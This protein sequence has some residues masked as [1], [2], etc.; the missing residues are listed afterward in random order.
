MN[1]TDIEKVLTKVD[2][3]E[4]LPTF[5]QIVR[6]C[7]LNKWKISIS[8]FVFGVTAAIVSSMLPN[9]Y[10][11]EALLVDSS[12]SDSD[13]LD[14]LSNSLGGLASIAGIELNSGD[15]NKAA[16]AQKV[17]VSRHFIQ[18]FIERRD[19]LVDLMAAE[20]WDLATNKLHFDNSIYS[21]ARQKWTR[22]V[23][24]PY[25]AKPSAQEA[26]KKFMKGYVVQ[27]ER[28]GGLVMISVDHV[29]PFIAK[30]WVEWLIED[31][32]DYMRRRDLVQMQSTIG[33]LQEQA[34]LSDVAEIKAIFYELIEH[35]TQTLILAESN[36]DY[37]FEVIDP[38]V[39]AERKISPN[40]FLIILIGIF[41]GASFGLAIV[42]GRITDR[43]SVV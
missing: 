32:N 3:S 19:I 21:V 13:M 25:K 28:Q 12:V 31:I 8:I 34:E 41:V 43:K 18:L 7:W 6:A 38:P 29:S 1:Q 10:R 24:L 15:V 2:L 30:K 40:R 26:F 35:K 17:L 16:V 9:I 27:Q 22:Q 42:M 14:A 23:N 39:I 33:Y 36:R 37:V 11:S 5:T 4:D 20:R